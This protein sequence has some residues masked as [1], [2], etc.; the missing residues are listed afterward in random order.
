[1]GSRKSHSEIYDY[2]AYDAAQFALEGFVDDILAGRAD[3]LAYVKN[4]N[5]HSIH[6]ADDA[7]SMAEGEGVD[8]HSSLVSIGIMALDVM[9]NA[10]KEVRQ[11]A[12][13]GRKA[14]EVLRPDDKRIEIR[15][16]GGALP[17]GK[18]TPV[19]PAVKQEM[20]ELARAGVPLTEI[21][22]QYG[23]AEADLAKILKSAGVKVV[24][25]V[26]A[27]PVAP[28]KEVIDL[29]LTGI[30]SELELRI[31]EKLIAGESAD[32]VATELGVDPEQIEAVRAAWKVSSASEA[33]SAVVAATTGPQ[34]KA[35]RRRE[36]P[37]A[38]QDL[39]RLGEDLI[40][41]GGEDG[42]RVEVPPFLKKKIGK[43]LDEL[44]QTLSRRG[45]TSEYSLLFTNVRRF[46]ERN[47][48][49]NA[50]NRYKAFSWK[51]ERIEELKGFQARLFVAT[52]RS[53]YPGGREVWRCGALHCIVK[54][55]NQTADED[56]DAA[57]DAKLRWVEWRKEQDAVISDLLKK[58][59]GR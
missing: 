43:A 53:V 31:A 49:T 21:V 19:P 12:R 27:P 56:L 11:Q 36:E 37:A 8:D 38:K 26:S 51:G 17:A 45:G 55:T 40:F 30:G 3:P 22:A 18:K 47:M 50:E 14:V 57:L 59:G 35:R 5:A 39:T 29:G 48:P 52:F 33:V 10:M 1:M 6:V 15:Y 28:Q 9:A 13:A 25:V 54:K 4:V 2:I 41:D 58:G 23:Y 7:I 34:A 24:P 20:A 46:A 42:F 32:A 16:E 44:R